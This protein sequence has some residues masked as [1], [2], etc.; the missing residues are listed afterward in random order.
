[1]EFKIDI[2]IIATRVAKTIFELL[3]PI[4]KT[5]VENTE[6]EAAEALEK[7]LIPIHHVDKNFIESL[8]VNEYGQFME[9]F[10]FQIDLLCEENNIPTE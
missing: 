3:D 4:S 5:T 2:R 8:T 10:Y 1:M 9:D 6:Q 7:N